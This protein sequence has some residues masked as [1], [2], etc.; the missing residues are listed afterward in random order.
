MRS[1]LANLATTPQR[2]GLLAVVAVV[3]GSIAYDGLGDSPRWQRTRLDLAVPGVPLDSLALLA[4]CLVVGVGL[5][6]ASGRRPPRR[7]AHAGVPIVVG[8]LVARYLTDLVEQG[9][10]TLLQLTDPLVRGDDL[11]GV[12]DATVSYWLSYHPTLLAWVTVLAILTG[13]LVGAIAWRDPVVGLV[14]ERRRVGSQLAML[15]FMVAFAAT[16]LSLLRAS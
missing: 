15:G 9:Q 10:S 1:P 16:G 4:C 14:P 11:L 6:L 8:Y 7:L 3:A 12:R 13:H 5:A 2:P